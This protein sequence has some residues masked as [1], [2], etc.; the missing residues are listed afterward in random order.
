MAS[1][2]TKKNKTK[3]AR[4]A[5]NLYLGVDGGGTKTH[6]VL[7]DNEKNIISEG[8][9]GASNPLR[10][11]VETAV[12]NIVKAVEAACDAA[13][14]SRGDI[15]SATLGL[16]GVRR[17]DL[18]QRVRESFIK[19]MPVKQ[20]EITT[21]A[22]IALYGVTLG[23]A[24]VVVISGT[25]SI[26]Y[27]KDGNGTTAMAGGWGP[28]AG[29]EG[30]GISIARRALQAI[31]RASDGRGEPTKLSD[32]GANY[33]R[34]STPANLLVAIYSPQMDN[35]KIAGFARFVVETAQAGDKVAVGILEEAG[36]EL[37]LAVNAVIGK[38]KLKNKKIPIGF[39]G[40]IFRAGELITDSLLETVHRFA[41]KAYPFQPFLQP[42]SAA[43]QSAFEM[44]RKVEKQ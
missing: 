43:A 1:V 16:A 39:V 42:A 28:I 26:C 36:L 40:S 13:N 38:L 21:D 6:V 44:Y 2:G 33:F 37:G 34:T 32:A 4:N 35:A 8:F 17:A 30:S 11:G 27:G 14:R 24:G 9:S 22:E 15:V 19:K 5:H 23:K 25:G 10:V 3:R 20:I 7:L 41:P 31:A 12:S 18:R 29:D